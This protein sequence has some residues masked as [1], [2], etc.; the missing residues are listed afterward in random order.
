MRVYSPGPAGTEGCIP[1]LGAA[2]GV[3][4]MLVA[5]SPGGRIPDPLE[6][7]P[8]IWVKSLAGRDAGGAGGAG[9]VDDGKPPGCFSGAG[10]GNGLL[11]TLVN[12]P[13]AP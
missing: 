2:C 13:G 4:N 10:V 6:G 9:G 5:L 1:A 11:N 8:N 3:E 7:C 12:S